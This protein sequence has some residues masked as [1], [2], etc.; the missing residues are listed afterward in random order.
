MYGRESFSLEEVQTALNSKN[1]NKR[2]DVKTSNLGDGLIPKGR[3]SN[4]E[5][6][7]NVRWKSKSKTRGVNIVNYFRCYHCKKEDHTRKYCPLRKRG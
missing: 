7:G 6:G 1:L 4:C 2:F 5:N 3:S